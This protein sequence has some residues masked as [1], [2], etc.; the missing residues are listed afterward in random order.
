MPREPA[1]DD[2]LPWSLRLYLL[3]ATGILVAFILTAPWNLAGKAIGRLTPALAFAVALA[4][5]A[6]LFRPWRRALRAGFL[7]RSHHFERPAELLLF[8][9]SAAFVL[10]VIL[11]RYNALE[12]NAWDFSVYELAVWRFTSS[13]VLFSPMEGRSQLGTHASYLLFVF[14][15]LYRLLS[16]HL[17]LLMAHAAAIAAAVTVA[18]AACRRILKDDLAAVLVAVALLA[19]TYTA[20]IV[21]YV[22][23][24]EVFY[25]V[26]VLLVAY[27]AIEKKSVLF[28]GALLLTTLVKEDSV[29]PLLGVCLAGL[30]F[31]RARWRWWLAGAAIAAAAFC[32]GTF[33]VI[34]HFASTVP[35][36]TW[37]MAMWSG[38][39]ATPAEAALGILRHPLRAG[40]D[41]AR[42]GVAGVLETL[43]FLPILGYEWF[44]AAIPALVAYGVSEGGRGGLAR[45]SIY[46]SA[47]VL[48]ILLLAASAGLARL[49]AK[50]SS[51]AGRQ[52]AVRIGSLGLLLLCAF[53]GASYVFLPARAS[54]LDIPTLQFPANT[55][56]RVQGALLPHIPLDARVAPLTFLTIEKDQSGPVL[57]D[58]DANPYPFSAVQLQD[59]ARRLSLSGY[60]ISH[61]PHGL[62]LASPRRT[63]S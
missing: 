37:Y 55:V 54:R 5:M 19:N 6:L 9:S 18:F 17:W 27:G 22:F 21:Q 56:M 11:S 38:Y 43:G 12:V 25:P 20:K 47:P 40:A 33:L 24:V 53:D 15:P 42:S 59:F 62:L 52:R 41:I 26:L 39:G 48:P 44:V 3:A 16:T 36:R 58:L 4:L 10:R 1:F 7:D 8:V 30:L 57:L 51:D 13:P 63:A 28:F 61:T 32:V 23:H 49:A 50:V 35:G 2:V 46:Y 60:A 34:P 29:L 31:A 45:F 14:P